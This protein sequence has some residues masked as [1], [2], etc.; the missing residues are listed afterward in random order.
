MSGGS[1]DEA[2]APRTGLGAQ[3]VF[4]CDAM[5]DKL[6]SLLRSSVRAQAHENADKLHNGAIAPVLVFPDEG[7]FL[8]FFSN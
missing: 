1:V 8:F 2:P 3:R 4:M 7:S 5:R 6:A